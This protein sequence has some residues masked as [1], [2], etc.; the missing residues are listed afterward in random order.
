MLLETDLSSNSGNTLIFEGIFRLKRKII[1]IASN[2]LH[3]KSSTKIWSFR[4]IFFLKSSLIHFANVA[5]GVLL[6]IGCV[7]FFSWDL[8]GEFAIILS[9]SLIS[10]QICVLG[11][12]NLMLAD[13]SESSLGNYHQIIIGYIKKV[14]KVQFFLTLLIIVLIVIDSFSTNLQFFKISTLGFLAVLGSVIFGP[15]NKLL[16]TV[17]TLPKYFTKFVFLSFARNLVM[18]TI[19]LLAI[20][21]NS[22]KIILFTLAFAE[23][24]LM[25]V[26]IFLLRSF[27]KSSLAQINLN[28]METEKSNGQKSVFL[29]NIYYE[30]LC[31]FDVF[32]FPYFMTPKLFGM[33]AVISS[34]NESVQTYLSSV[35]IQITPHYSRKSLRTFAEDKINLYFVR[36]IL[37]ILVLLGLVFLLFTYRISGETLPNWQVIYFC[38]ILSSLVLF[39]SL[40]YGYVFIQKRQYLWL[41]RTAALH[42][43]VLYSATALSFHFLGMLVAISV[44]IAVNI[45]FGRIIWR[46]LSQLV[47]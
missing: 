46:K 37:S 47:N 33:Y 24:V 43:I 26:T 11:N 12:P 35:R 45:F 15:Y 22:S 38:I 25:I 10:T 31:K 13:L 41:A 44:V 30:L 19:L 42:L 27:R 36:F 20:T 14:F 4:N 32:V 2:I 18:L 40:I 39:R 9:A 8:Y 34:I 3:V 21:F 5:T 23:I 1:S 16:F 28:S 29:I 6:L 7:K 17:L